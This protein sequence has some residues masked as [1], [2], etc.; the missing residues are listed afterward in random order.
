MIVRPRL[1]GAER[2]LGALDG[3]VQ[4]RRVDRQHPRLAAEG[5]HRAADQAEE[6][7]LLGFGGDVEQAN[8]G[9]LVEAEHRVVHQGDGGSAPFA[10]ADAVALAQAVVAARRRPSSRV[11]ALHLDHAFDRDEV[12]DD[13][14]AGRRRRLTGR[15]AQGSPDEDDSRDQKAQA[16]SGFFSP[17]A[18]NATRTQKRAPT[19]ARSVWASALPLA[20]VT[21]F[22]EETVQRDPNPAKLFS[23]RQHPN[24]P[25]YRLCAKL[26]CICSLICL[27][28]RQVSVLTTLSPAE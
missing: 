5:L 17:S 26:R 24:L 9:P 12:A 6:G 4:V 8:G 15:D 13:R 1:A 10:G 2:E 28:S 3:G 18:K 11:G 16:E 27:C 20:L 14:R 25:H 22:V 19:A 23:R 7:A 21:L